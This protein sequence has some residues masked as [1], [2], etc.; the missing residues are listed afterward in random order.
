MLGIVGVT[1]FLIVHVLF[2]EEPNNYIDIL[3]ASSNNNK[4]LWGEC[5]TR[6]KK[7]CVGNSTVSN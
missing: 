5:V 7:I 3:I 2:F 1:F 4:A 6:Q